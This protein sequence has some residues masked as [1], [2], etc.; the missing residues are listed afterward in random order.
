MVFKGVSCERDEQAYER[1]LASAR[2][3]HE[4]FGLKTQPESPCVCFSSLQQEDSFMFGET[5]RLFDLSGRVALVTGACGHLGQRS[6][7]DWQ[8]PELLWL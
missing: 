5:A 4:E 2:T 3:Q 8:K 7:K 1:Y 6:L